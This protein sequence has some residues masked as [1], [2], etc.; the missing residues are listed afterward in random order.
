MGDLRG[1]SCKSGTGEA[2][3]LGL[4]RLLAVKEGRS[5]PWLGERQH[6]GHLQWM[7]TSPF[8]RVA[9][10]GQKEPLCLVEGEGL[11]T[12]EKGEGLMAGVKCLEGRMGCGV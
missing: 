5:R 12:R 3:T 7:L 1:S 4:G 11:G 8:F 2:I 10:L 6:E 9:V